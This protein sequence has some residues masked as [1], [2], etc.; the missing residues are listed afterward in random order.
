[1]NKINDKPNFFKVNDPSVII[2]ADERKKYY[3]GLKNFL[4]FVQE[5][6]NAS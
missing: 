2:E 4:T 3:E 1:L 5:S 6:Q